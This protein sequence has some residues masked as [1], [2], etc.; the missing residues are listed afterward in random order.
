M[1]MSESPA[2][3]T[4]QYTGRWIEADLVPGGDQPLAREQVRIWHDSGYAFV[5]GLLPGSLV[6]TLIDSVTRAVPRPGSEDSERFTGFG[7]KLSFPSP[8]AGFNELT[9]EPGLLAAVAQLLSVPVCQLRLTQ[10]T[11]WPKYGRKR[12]E[13]GRN[14]NQ[15]QRIHVDYPNHTLVHP[16]E[17]SRP[18]AVEII[19]YLGDV[20]TAG[21]PTAVVPRAGPEDPLYQW[22]IVDTPGVG[23]L[24]YVNDKA[25]AEAY[26]AVQRPEIASWRAQLYRSERYVHF[27]A[28]DVLLYRHDTWHRGTPMTEGKL[29]LAHN[30]TFRRADAEWISTL[31]A[32]WAWSAYRP[33]KF[34]EKLI[35]RASLDQRAV[36]G[37]PQPGSHYWTPATIKAVEARHGP[38]GMDM[39]PYRAALAHRD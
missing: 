8:L 27:H 35:A 19:V 14:D 33:G 39:T 25:A 2:N 29:R 28:G 26:L 21:G 38:F 17:W 32:G 5:A 3:I 31:H 16:P 12:R 15:D 34:F 11:A 1:A 9:L 10:S 30:L 24:D 22:P 13:G 18:E 7:S 6:E 37:F 36:M 23:E 4:D 20:E